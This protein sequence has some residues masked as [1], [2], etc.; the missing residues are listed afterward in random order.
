MT[1]ISNM[2][3]ML[4]VLR[5]GIVGL[6]SNLLIFIIYLSITG[7]GVGHKSSMSLLFALGVIQTF[8]FNKR[9]TF[10]HEG[11][12]RASFLRY[13]IIYILAY[14]L[15]FM[16]LLFLVDKL[17]YPHQVVQGLL[18]LSISLILFLLQKFWV[19]RSLEIVKLA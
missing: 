3:T 7:F 19:F 9:W 10:G 12:L 2:T 17:G 16:A 4:Q 8:V 1:T 6:I 11:F 18:I 13:V 15:N 14:F 5:F